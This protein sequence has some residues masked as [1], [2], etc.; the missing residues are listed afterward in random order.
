MPGE[1]IPDPEMV[2]AVADN[3]QSVFGFSPELFYVH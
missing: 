2:F 3:K 1:Q